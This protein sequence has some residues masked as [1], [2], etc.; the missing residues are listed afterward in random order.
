[1]IPFRLNL[2]KKKKKINQLIEKEMFARRQETGTELTEEETKNFELLRVQRL[3]EADD[4]IHKLELNLIFYI[5]KINNVL[6]F[7]VRFFMWIKDLFYETFGTPY[8]IYLYN[9]ELDN[10]VAS[11]SHIISPEGERVVEVSTVE[12]K[13]I[14]LSLDFSKYWIWKRSGI[15]K[16]VNK[17]WK[18]RGGVGE[19]YYKRIITYTKQNKILEL[20][21]E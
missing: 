11:Y 10:Y 1:M 16:W 19:Y 9:K 20:D 2:K 17:A 18:K 13:G 3:D 8:P 12:S 5:N 7:I 15:K 6:I 21:G 14:L 4:R